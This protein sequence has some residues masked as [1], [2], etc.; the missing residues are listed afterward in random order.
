[1]FSP[2]Q[3]NSI[4]ARSFVCFGLSCIPSI[5]KNVCGAHIIGWANEWMNL[6]AILLHV[7]HWHMCR[8]REISF[9]IWD[10]YY[11]CHSCIGSV[12][13]TWAPPFQ[14]SSEHSET[15]VVPRCFLHVLLTLIFIVLSALGMRKGLRHFIF[16]SEHLVI[17]RLN[18]GLV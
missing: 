5:L 1:M 10:T 7:I 12:L 11:L 14:W 13:T 16:F 4:R 8:K 2:L 3:V 9:K 6:Y 15:S 17:L 18:L